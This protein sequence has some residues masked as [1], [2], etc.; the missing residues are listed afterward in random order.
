MDAQRA[1]ETMEANAPRAE[2]PIVEHVVY[3]R[4]GAPLLVS[5]AHPLR[6]GLGLLASTERELFAR[7]EATHKD[8]FS[9]SHLLGIE[10]RSKFPQSTGLLNSLTETILAGNESIYRCSFDFSFLKLA[11]GK[12]PAADEGVYYEGF[13]LDSHPGIKEGHELLRLLLNLSTHTREFQYC[14]TDWRELVIL[15]VCVG[16]REFFPLRVPDSVPRKTV[17]LPGCTET[18]IHGL[19]F[20]ASVLPHVGINRECGYFLASFEALAKFPK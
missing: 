11:R 7:P 18:T 1:L 6:V 14:E 9:S 4:T 17:L 19:R 16:R 8:G 5:F 3:A 2:R 20:W 15:G 10:E 13:H 12:P